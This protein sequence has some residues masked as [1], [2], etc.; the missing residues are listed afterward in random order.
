MHFFGTTVRRRKNRV[1]AHI[2]ALS[3][4]MF[5]FV[6]PA[7]VDSGNANRTR[8]S[9]SLMDDDHLYFSAFV[10]GK[11]WFLK[12]HFSDTCWRVK[13]DTPRSVFDNGA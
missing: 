5:F 11:F 3:M 13:S 4:L 12:K 6:T 10:T 8:D 7:F 9:D 1:A 2:D